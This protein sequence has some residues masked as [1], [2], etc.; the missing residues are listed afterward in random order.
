M[1]YRDWTK[2][3]GSG[4]DISTSLL[5]YGCM[6]FPT[7][8]DGRIDEV[9]A[10]KLLNTAREAGVNYFDTA[11]PYH[12]GESEPFVG[13]VIAKWPRESFYLATKL[14]V[15]NCKT[16]DEAKA[17]FEQQ[18]QRLG[19]DYA[20][21]LPNPDSLLVNPQGEWN[22]SRIVCDNGHVEHWLNGR[23]ILEFEAWTDDWFARKNSGKWE[24]AP[25][26][27]LAHR[28]VLCLQDHGYPASFR[29]LKIK[30]LPRKAGREVELFNGR[31]LTGW[32]AYGTEKWYVDKEGN[33]VCESGPDKKYGYLAT[34]EYYDDFDLTVEFKQLANG[35]SGVFFRS[36]VEPPVKVHGWQCEV[37]PKNHDTAGIYESYGRGWLVQIPDEKESILKEGDWNT[38][39]LKVQGDRVQTWL[40]GEEMVDITDAKIG[41][42]QGRI[43]LQIHDGGGIKVLWRNIRLTTL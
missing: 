1:E 29:N 32:E 12:G 6:R 13:R 17:I 42:A 7:L 15:W 18:F 43:A 14:P 33:L 27:G 4:R 10:E 30:E 34:R 2:K 38:L 26:Y 3:D 21:H 25:E 22:S 28:G 16:L 19:V 23:K 41:A 39:R 36:F 40:N 9:R 35:N 20:M 8:P 37:A 5:G 31:D 11:F 24:T